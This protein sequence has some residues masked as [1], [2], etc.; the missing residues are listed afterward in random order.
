MKLTLAI[1]GLFLILFSCT[2]EPYRCNCDKSE[3]ATNDSILQSSE[4]IKSIP[5]FSSRFNQKPL[6]ENGVESY[7]LSTKH[8]FNEY[9]QV[10]TLSKSKDGGDFLI[11]EYLYSSPD[12]R[13]GKLSNEHRTKLSTEEWN[14]FKEVIEKNCFWTLPI[15]APD[16]GEYFDGGEW[17]IEGF[18]PNKRNCFNS[19]YMITFRKRPSDSKQ[20]Y[21]I[22]LSI[23]KMVDKDEIHETE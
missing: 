18:Q 9:Y 19:D 10:Y 15:D 3:V 17:Y 23:M 22:F 5:L 21:N 13:L 8:S 11:Q 12:D 20:F 4:T 16:S 2:E 6:S 1:F 14:S 7:R